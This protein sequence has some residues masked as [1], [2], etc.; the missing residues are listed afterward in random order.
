[1]KQDSLRENVRLLKAVNHISYKEIAQYMEMNVNSFYN[2]MSGAFDLGYD[3]QK[4]LE[5]ILSE[6]GGL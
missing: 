6:I 2:F 1:M 4:K 3:N 5:R